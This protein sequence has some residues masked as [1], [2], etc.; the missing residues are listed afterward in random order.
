M[1]VKET[2]LISVI[3]PIYNVEKY[4]RKCLDSLA[5]Q[6]MKEIEVICIDDGSTDR[7]GEI[8]NEYRNDE[9]FRIIHTEN[10]GLSAA[11]NMGIDEA[12][13]PWIM[14]VDSDDWVDERF[15]EIPYR[16]AIENDADLVIFGRYTVKKNGRIKRSDVQIHNGLV[17][18]FTAHEFGGNAAW[19]KLYSKSMYENIRYPESLLFEDV[20]ITYRIV[21]IAKQIV[22]LDDRLYYHVIRPN[23]I[24]Q[25]HSEKRHKD[26]LVS[27]IIKYNDLIIRGYPE[28]KLEA[29]LYSAAMGYLATT[30]AN[31]DE[32]RE[33]A[34]QIL[35]SANYLPKQ[36]PI[37]KKAALL[38]WKIDKRWF[39]FASRIIERFRS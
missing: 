12:R 26:S 24:T 15:C 37:W 38:V 6:T 27:N 30:G 25:T 3:V 19:N 21:C 28:T 16:A 2:P 39:Y 1:E 32:L 34:E 7:S 10:R 9:R 17:D 18:E 11:R 35:Y 22:M 23:S 4:V 33:Q 29:Q 5:A 20:A 13:A 36:L 14:F 31:N 8:A